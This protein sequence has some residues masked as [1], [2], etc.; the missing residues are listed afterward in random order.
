MHAVCFF[1]VPKTIVSDLAVYHDRLELSS[2]HYNK[3]NGLS[4]AAIL[5]VNMQDN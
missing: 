1:V 3:E 4:M 5:K 2:V